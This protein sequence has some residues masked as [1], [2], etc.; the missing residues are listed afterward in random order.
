MDVVVVEAA[1]GDVD[2]PGWAG[3][4]AWVPIDSTVLADSEYIWP[5]GLLLQTTTAQNAIDVRN[6][7][8]PV[9]TINLPGKTGCVERAEASGSRV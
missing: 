2:W 9:R 3:I 6:R 5:V 4:Q 1:R 7:Q 8:L